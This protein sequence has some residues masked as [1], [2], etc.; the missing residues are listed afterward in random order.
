MNS[1]GSVALRGLAAAWRGSMIAAWFEGAPACPEALKGAL[2]PRAVARTRWVWPAGAAVLCITG[3]VFFP[4]ARAALFL[5]LLGGA[6]A[7]ACPTAATLLLPA[8]LVWAPKTPLLATG[9]E[10][11]FFR[12]DHA[13]LA[14]LLLRMASDR[15]TAGQGLLFPAALFF[16]TLAAS[17]LAGVFRGTVQSAGPALM[18]IGQMGCLFAVFFAARTYAPSQHGPG[19]W[20]W[21]L[22]VAALAGFGV[23]EQLAPGGPVRTFESGYF[24]G[25]ANHAGGVFAIAASAGFALCFHRR[26]RTL[27]AAVALACIVA[28]AGTRSR[29]A[30]AALIAGTGCAAIAYRPILLAPVACASF[31][32]A[33]FV[34][35]AWWYALSAP[36]TSLFDRMVHWKAALSTVPDFP[37][38]GLGPG[39][40]H[41]QFY[42]N[43]WIMLLAETGLLGA[44]AFAF[45]LLSV[46]RELMRPGL[47][48]RPWRVA[49]VAAFAA[50]AMQSLAAVAFLA[51]MIAGPLYWLCGCAIAREE[52]GP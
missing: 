39:A 11:V 49:A 24:E 23:A 8:A 36:G 9:G 47:I 30:G 51:T 42:D 15:R 46:A 10:S 2:I 25:Q 4:F 19:A 44:A 18:F 43:H 40:R 1:G 6:F 22:P 41:R 48:A 26:W 35:D 17:L 31:A 20:A 13:L 45:W 29:E 12:V 34:P 21:I 50:T 28:L 5:L 27:G 16:L 38:L 33:L 32:A 3:A 14:G 37:L 7:Y 52:P